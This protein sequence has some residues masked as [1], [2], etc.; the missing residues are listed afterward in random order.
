MENTSAPSRGYGKK[1]KK[2]L[3]IYVAVGAV[4]YLAVYLIIHAGSGSGGLY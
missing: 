3:A 4:V 2:W 1:W